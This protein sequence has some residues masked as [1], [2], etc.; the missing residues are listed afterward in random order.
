V[1][2]GGEDVLRLKEEGKGA[3]KCEAAEQ[4]KKGTGYFEDK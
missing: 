3:V 2:A 4:K 1:V